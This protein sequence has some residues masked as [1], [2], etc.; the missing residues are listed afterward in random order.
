M[1]LPDILS[2]VLRSPIG[3][4]LR[5]SPARRPPSRPP[6]P[7]FPLK[8]ALE[9]Q[10]LLSANSSF[11]SPQ[12]DYREREYALGRIP[13]TFTRREGQPKDREIIIA[14]AIDRA[15][16]PLFPRGYLYDTQITASTLCADGT[17]ARAAA[18]RAG[19]PAA[20]LSRAHCRLLLSRRK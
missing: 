1:R 9:F 6:G 14:R 17:Q 11:R 19:G 13:S 10:S 3:V 16:R 2:N 4:F 18:H 12:I 15:V 5:D 7:T 20:A 8:R